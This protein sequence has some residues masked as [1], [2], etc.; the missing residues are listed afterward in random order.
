MDVVGGQRHSPSALPPGK[1]P[2]T[3]VHEAVWALVPVWM[4]AQNLAPTGIQT[5]DTLLRS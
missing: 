2:V 4:G 3:F 1:D 5:T